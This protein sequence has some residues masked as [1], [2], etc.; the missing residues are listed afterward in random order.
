M[1]SKYRKYARDLYN[2]RI[3]GI[4]KPADENVFS[5]NKLLEKINELRPRL[6]KELNDL[7]A[8]FI[9][10]EPE[11]TPVLME[12]TKEVNS[13]FLRKLHAL[14]NQIKKKIKNLLLRTPGSS[15]Q[16]KS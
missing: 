7:S 12:E 14:A 5:L 2:I 13:L 4:G 6:R 3:N 15:P 11:A 8:E 1:L 10:Q 9:A 16:P